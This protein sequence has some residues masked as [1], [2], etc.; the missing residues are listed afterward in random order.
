MATAARRSANLTTLYT[1]AKE[2]WYDKEKAEDIIFSANPLLW[3]LSQTRKV[4]G[5][6]GFDILVRILEAKNESVTSFAGYQEIVPSTP[7]GPQAARFSMAN[8]A[9]AIQM[10][11]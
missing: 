4:T 5:S 7:R 9:A 8:Y 1:T 11:W 2:S 10:S 3:I 6:W